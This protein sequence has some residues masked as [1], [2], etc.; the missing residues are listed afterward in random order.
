MH[1][2]TIEDKARLYITKC[3][4]DYRV[5]ELLRNIKN[6]DEDLYKHSLNVAFIT[7]QICYMENFDKEKKKAIVIA[8]LLHDVGK[9]AIPIEITGKQGYLSEEEYNTMKT[10]VDKGVA[11]LTLYNFSERVKTYVQ[12][13]HNNITDGGYPKTNKN[14]L[15]GA[16]IISLVDKYDALTSKR[17]YGAIYSKEEALNILKSEKNVDDKYIEMLEMCKAI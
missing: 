5:N 9:T 14:M 2:K 13:H 15:S 1:R 4:L 10:H 17:P 6:Y 11:I 12:M 3:S 8:S 7:A 16:K